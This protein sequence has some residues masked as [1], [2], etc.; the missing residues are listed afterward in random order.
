MLVLSGDNGRDNGCLTVLVVNGVQ[1]NIGH[2]DGT[3][4]SVI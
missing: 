2:P 1:H 4:C 3:E